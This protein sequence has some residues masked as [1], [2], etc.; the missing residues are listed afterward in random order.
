MV[1]FCSALWLSITS[2]C[3]CSLMSQKKYHTDMRINIIRVISQGQSLW[4]WQEAWHSHGVFQSCVS[5][6]HTHTVNSG[7]CCQ[8]CLEL[9]WYLKEIQEELGINLKMS[10]FFF[11]TFLT[12]LAHSLHLYWYTETHMPYGQHR[13]GAGKLCSRQ[14]TKY[15]QWLFLFLCLASVLQSGSQPWTWQLW[16]VP[17]SR[18][19]SSA[20][21]SASRGIPR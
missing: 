15:L 5:L 14:Y 3:F 19:S 6:T 16:T 10:L 11:F 8:E 13:T 4:W 21:H 17:H 2:I 1:L 9:S 20:L 12:I 18:T 7:S